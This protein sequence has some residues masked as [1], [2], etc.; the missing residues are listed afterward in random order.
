MCNFGGGRPADWNS[1]KQPQKDKSA[2]HLPH[3]ADE[4]IAKTRPDS[5]GSYVSRKT[6]EKLHSRGAIITDFSGNLITSF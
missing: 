6:A 3:R 1:N 2:P 5:P 4:F